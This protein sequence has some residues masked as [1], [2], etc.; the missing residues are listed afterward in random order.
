[1]GSPGMEIGDQF[2][3]YDVMVLKADGSA[4]VYAHIATKNEQY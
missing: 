2:S 1:M 4:Q 3:P